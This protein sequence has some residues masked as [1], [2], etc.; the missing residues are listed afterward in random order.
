MTRGQV[1]SG[2]ASSSQTLTLGPGAKQ[3]TRIDLGAA[4]LTLNATI[5][6]GAT[7]FTNVVY[8]VSPINA[9]GS[10]G[11]PVYEGGSN[12]GVSTIVPAGRWHIAASDDQGRTATVTTDLIIGQELSMNLPLSQ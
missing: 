5:P 7:P 12:D 10:V 6:D 9:D 4:R 2:A 8:T 1:M 11:D 3:A